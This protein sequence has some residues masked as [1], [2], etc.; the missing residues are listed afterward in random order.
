MKP[1]Q[2]IHKY[3][4]RKLGSWKTKGHDVYKC[5]LPGCNH[6]LIDLETVV[7][8]LSQCWGPSCSNEVEM[9][10]FIVFSEKRKRPLCDTCKEERRLRRMT[11]EQIKEEIAREKAIEQLFG[12]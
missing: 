8:R 2:H 6:Y 4:R 5:S 9:T 3:E 12:D 10:R 7:G 1:Q 11:P